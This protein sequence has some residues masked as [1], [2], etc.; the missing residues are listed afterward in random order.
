MKT[1]VRCLA[2]VLLAACAPSK[3]APVCAPATSIAR[4]PISCPHGSYPDPFR[5]Q[6]VRVA[7]QAQQTPSA[8]TP[9]AHDR[10][11]RFGISTR[12]RPGVSFGRGFG[13]HIDHKG[14]VGLGFGL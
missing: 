11:L 12:G 14:R 9:A 13:L 1:L 4:A 10:G 2:V 3:E 5:M 6:C 8:P 7:G